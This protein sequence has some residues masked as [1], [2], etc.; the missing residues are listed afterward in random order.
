MPGRDKSSKNTQAF[1]QTSDG[2]PDRTTNGLACH[3]ESDQF[4]PSDQPAASLFFEASYQ[5]DSISRLVLDTVGEG[6][7][8]SSRIGTTTFVNPAAARMLGW[9]VEDLIGKNQHTIVHHSYPDGSHYPID[10]CP[11]LAVFRTGRT[12]HCEDEVFWRRDGSSFAVSYTSTPIITDGF[13]TGAVVVFRDISQQTRRDLWQRSK[14]AIFQAITTC[15][16]LES[17]LQLLADAYT[18]YQPGCSIAILLRQEE[19]QDTLALVAGS[20]LSAALK[21]RLQHLLIEENSSVCGRAAFRGQE[22]MGDS[23]RPRRPELRRDPC[24]SIASVSCPSHV[25]RARTRRWRGRFFSS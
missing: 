20:A 11:I 3:E 17:T 21:A 18:S 25:L 12:E 22:I 2:T 13:V 19:Q 16:P 24:D 5:I 9:A 7:F 15:Q 4:E 1:P 10:A 6:I 23:T 14:S 8:C